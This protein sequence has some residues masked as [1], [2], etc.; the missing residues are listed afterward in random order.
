MT[1]PQ[2][3]SIGKAL[4]RIPSGVF[5]LTARR[6]EQATAMLA[7]WVQQ[8]SFEPPTIVFAVG[9]DRAVRLMLTA[10]ARVAVSVLGKGDHVLMKRYAR[11]VAEGEDPFSGV[12]TGT[13]PAGATYLAGAAAWLECRVMRELDFDS[14]HVL[15]VAEVTGGAV[16]KEDAPFTHVRG[17]GF[18]Y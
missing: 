2:R 6:G 5:V 8:A 16:L 4:G 3:Q 15:Y 13:T 11:G 9:K 10:D 17:N 14:D 1:D 7:S 12:E 18:H